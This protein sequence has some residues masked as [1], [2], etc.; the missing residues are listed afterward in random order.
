MT[1]ENKD[2]TP[3]KLRLSRRTKED[4]AEA[5]ASSPEP[6]PKPDLKLKRPTE[7]PAQFE[8]KKEDAAP[9]SPGKPVEPAPPK[10]PTG[11]QVPPGKPSTHAAGE[12]SYDPENPFADIE[13]KQPKKEATEQAPPELP[14][15]PAPSQNDESDRKFEEA[16]DRI[17]ESPKSHGVLTSLIV[18]TLLLAILG[19]AGYGLY[20]ILSNPSEA[21][22]NTAEPDANKAAA[23]STETSDDAPERGPI[24]KARETIANLPDSEAWR[25]AK[26]ETTASEAEQKTGKDVQE[27]APK[28]DEATE[29]ATAA[30]EAE[31]E[32]APEPPTID[33]S[34]TDSISEFL[35]TAH[36]GGVRTGDQPKL[37]LNGQSYNKGDLIDADN[38]LRFIG[39]R[40]GKIAFRDTQGVVYIKSF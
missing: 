26:D 25:D 30:P 24:A 27:K 23:A 38:G 10:Q 9:E 18:I 17:G 3:P 34:R 39:I 36:V 16:V 35:Q 4:D 7:D 19:G 20:Y 6:E 12:R 29:A 33:A 22:E 28:P 31:A 21:T 1:E 5:Q 11:Q 32:P 15:K 13:I 2:A 40:D 14:G 8:N 37:I